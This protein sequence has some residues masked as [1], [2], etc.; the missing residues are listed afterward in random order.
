MRARADRDR[1]RFARPPVP[2]PPRRRTRRTGDGRRQA[3]H[4]RHHGADEPLRGPR[5]VPARGSLLR[6]D[7]RRQPPAARHVTTSPRSTKRHTTSSSCSKT[8]AGCGW[9]T[10]SLGCSV[11]DAA[12][13]IDGIARHHAYWWDNDRLA[14][15]P[16][17]MEYN[18]PRFIAAI[19]ENYEAAWPKFRRA[20]CGPVPCCCAISA[21]GSNRRSRGFSTRSRV[22][23]T[24]S[25]TETYGSTS[26]SSPSA[27]T[28]RR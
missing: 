3:P 18:S 2:S 6:R 11:E 20:R 25:C 9:P 19:T 4:A 15:L 27:P 8:W 26:C 22:G 10:S 1:R 17:L 14:S 5:D 24:P 28:T 23:R 21:T 16:W 13:V 12:T 7:R